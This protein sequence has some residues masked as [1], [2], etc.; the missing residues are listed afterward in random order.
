MISSWL[1][2]QS[3]PL[4]SSL[5][6]S[7]S[8]SKSREFYVFRLATVSRFFFSPHCA[9]IKF[10]QLFAPSQTKRTVLH[11]HFSK[12]ISEDN[13]RSKLI[14][15]IVLIEAYWTQTGLL[16]NLLDI[17]I[18]KGIPLFFSF[19]SSSAVLATLVTSFVFWYCSHSFFVLSVFL[20]FT[21]VLR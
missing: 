14:Q 20:S 19:F 8:S 2:R 9:L 21:M 6:D 4:K 18:N 7:F 1:S 16:M 11:L 15:F 5:V 3:E 10:L 12:K 17:S 13:P